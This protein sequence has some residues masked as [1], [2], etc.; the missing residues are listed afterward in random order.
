MA[1]GETSKSTQVPA[2]L[3][4]HYDEIITLTDEFCKQHLNKEYRDLCRLLTAKLCRKRPSPLVTGKPQTWA[5]GI[6][7]AMGRVNFLF[8]KSQKPYMRADDLCSHFGLSA[9]TGS[10]KSTAIMKILNS[11]QADPEWTLPSQLANNPMAWFIR[12][13]GFLMDARQ[14]PREVQEEA[15]R[16]GLIPYLP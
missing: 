8:D 14:A 16:L 5:C 3:Q 10:A 4:G 11:G 15:F 6:V 1:K 13:N 9:S 12:V 7:Y 2:A